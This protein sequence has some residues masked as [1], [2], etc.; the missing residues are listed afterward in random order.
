VR[1]VRREAIRALA[2]VRFV[3]LPGPEGR[4][5]MLYPA[6]TLARVCM[7]DT[8][9]IDPVLGPPPTS[10]E[11]AEAV[12]GLCN[13]A[14]VWES[15]PIKSFNNDALALAV[16]TGLVHFAGPRTDPSDKSLPWMGYGLRI[17]EAMGDWP[18]IFSF[19]HNPVKPNPAD[20]QAAPAVV[21]DVIR[22]AQTSILAP[23]TAK[24]G[25]V[26]LQDLRTFITQQLGKKDVNVLFA[27][28]PQMTLPVEEKP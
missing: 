24:D 27:N 5:N 22:R 2:Q 8:T 23:M 9:A 7:A 3:M 10:S 6:Y 21:K 16:A 15:E 25:Q 17:A 1:Y 14:P 19:L 26:N 4:E 20:A 11:R 18:P 28:Q 13:M 12:L